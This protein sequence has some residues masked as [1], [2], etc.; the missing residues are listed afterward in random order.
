MGYDVLAVDA[1]EDKVEEVS[2]EVTHA[3]QADVT[4]EK[5]LLSLGIRNFD[6]V[7]VSIGEDVQAN[8]M[9]TLLVK[10]LGVEEVIVKSQNKLHAKVL[11]KI[12]RG[13]IQPFWTRS[14]LLTSNN[15][16]D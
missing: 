3:V 5:N 2:K 9:T 7:I 13:F 1:S 11:E 12:G 15:T 14:K 6:V 8:I 10:E 4:L 16:T